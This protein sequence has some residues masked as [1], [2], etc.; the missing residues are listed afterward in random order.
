MVTVEQLAG[1]FRASRN[2][3][4]CAGPKKA[5]NLGSKAKVSSQ[6]SGIFLADS[7]RSVVFPSAAIW[8]WRQL[9]PSPFTNKPLPLLT[10][11]ARSNPQGIQHLRTAEPGPLAQPPSS[12]NKASASPAT[13]SG[14]RRRSKVA[15][16]PP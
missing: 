12:S 16:D 15:M 13:R 7:Q 14:R 6:I 2:A 11:R 1:H 4:G 10:L 8:G 3:A 9:G 5:K